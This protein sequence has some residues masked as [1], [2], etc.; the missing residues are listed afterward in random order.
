MNVNNETGKKKNEK[1]EK[2]IY[3]IVS[4]S[5]ENMGTELQSNHKLETDHYLWKYC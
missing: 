1:E 5:V 3:R 4:S 2:G